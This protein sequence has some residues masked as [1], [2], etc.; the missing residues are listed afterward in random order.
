[1]NIYHCIHK[2]GKI[3]LII[4]F[5]FSK[6]QKR[7]RIPSHPS[8]KSHP[9][10]HP[11]PQR[12]ARREGRG[13]IIALG[14]QTQSLSPCCLLVGEGGGGEGRGEGG[15]G[16]EGKGVEKRRMTFQTIPTPNNGLTHGNR[17]VTLHKS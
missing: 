17:Q 13:G 6:T 14:I 16:M 12:A 10:L 11:T 5:F 8:L 1:M 2:C 9:S 3:C 15:G 4:K 7:Y